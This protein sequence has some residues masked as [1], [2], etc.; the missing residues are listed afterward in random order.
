M[1]DNLHL[2]TDIKETQS[3]GEIGDGS[4]AS[5]HTVGT[6]TAR[7]AVEGRMLELAIGEVA[8]VKDS[9][10]NL[11]QLRAEEGNTGYIKIR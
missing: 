11:R 1:S 3:S 6:V 10:T 8:C 9:T 2:L 7:S 4:I 5:I